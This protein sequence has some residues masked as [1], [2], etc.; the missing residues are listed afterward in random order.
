MGA[1]RSTGPIKP[2]LGAIE[3]EV[4]GSDAGMGIGMLVGSSEGCLG[5]NRWFFEAVLS[6]NVS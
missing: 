2:T 5:T 4:G 3:H 6:F 1:G